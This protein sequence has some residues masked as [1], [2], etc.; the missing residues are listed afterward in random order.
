M[1]DRPE[2]CKKCGELEP[3]VREYCGAEQCYHRGLPIKLA[4]EHLH[5][6][7]T[8]CGYPWIDVCVDAK[9][10]EPQVPRCPSEN[11]IIP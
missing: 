1:S 9:P 3:F 6:R 8:G 5:Y 4:E 11:P 2:R 10:K 7:C